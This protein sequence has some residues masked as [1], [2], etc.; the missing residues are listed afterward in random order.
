MENTLSIEKKKEY[1]R[2]YWNCKLEQEILE[3]EIKEFQTSQSAPH[4]FI[5]SIP[6]SRFQKDYSDYICALEEKIRKLQRQR[7][8]VIQQYEDIVSLIES[9]EDDTEKLVLRLKYIHGYTLEK[10]AEKMNYSLRQINN[11]HKKALLH[12]ILHT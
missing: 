5:E 7:E 11:I 3:N 8:Q 4:H 10:I 6:G 12:L 9:L 1:L 2:S